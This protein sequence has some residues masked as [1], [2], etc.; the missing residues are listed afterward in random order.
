MKKLPFSGVVLMLAGVLPYVLCTCAIVFYD[1]HM[2]V[3]NLLM[4]LVLY[5]AISLSFIGAVHWGQALEPERTIIVASEAQTDHMRLLL[6]VVP[7]LVGWV[8]ACVGILWQPLWGLALLAVAFP[9]VAFGERAAWRRGWVPP[10]YMGV[11]WIV[12]AVTECCLLMVL[13]VR[14]L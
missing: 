14:L 5:G 1:S 9:L 2:P 8:A 10:G 7:A 13:L 12:T 4:A 11:R 3:P 6:G